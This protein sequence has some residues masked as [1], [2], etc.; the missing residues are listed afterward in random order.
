MASDGTFN[1]TDKAQ[2][3]VLM[4]LTGKSSSVLYEY[5]RKGAL[6]NPFT[7]H[8]YIECISTLTA[9]LSKNAEARLAKVKADEAIQ[10]AKLEARGGKDDKGGRPRNGMND[11]GEMHPL[12]AAKTVQDI[13]VNI[14]RETQI[15]VKTA[16]ERGEYVSM[17]RLLEMVEPFILTIRQRLIELASEHEELEPAIDE[18]MEGLFDVGVKL[19]EG[20]I[21]DEKGFVQAILDKEIDPDEIELND[22]PAI[23]L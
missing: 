14:A 23:L 3:R 2:A 4:S 22:V 9:Y 16:I 12:V 7:E 1:L 19:S 21:R 20:S 8:S 17:P 18:V 10:I 6:P 5:Q 15:W 13:R 11:D